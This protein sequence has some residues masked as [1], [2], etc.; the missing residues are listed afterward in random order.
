M[1][2]QRSTVCTVFGIFHFIVAGLGVVIILFQVSGLAQSF[3]NFGQ[4]GGGK[5]EQVQ[6]DL[7]EALKN[8]PAVQT[9]EMVDLGTKVMLTGLL[10]IAGVG[11]VTMKPWGRILS[12]VYAVLSLLSKVVAIIV[13]FTVIVPAIKPIFED[14][15]RRDPQMGSAMELGG[16]IGGAVG[17][18]ILMIYPILVL[19]FM[20]LPST[21]RGLRRASEDQ[22]EESRS[23][24]NEADDRWGR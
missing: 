2:Q 5:I 18:C 23:D 14:I 21:A 17:P 15:K 9:M 3:A 10:I 12:L 13:H 19:I 20:L 11:L 6:K 4:G 1:A 22:P 7:V 16:T 8:L 24:L